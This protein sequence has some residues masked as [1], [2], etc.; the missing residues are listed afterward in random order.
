[1]SDCA[2]GESHI[3]S[4]D[5]LV[6]HGRESCRLRTR[7]ERAKYDAE[8]SAIVLKEADER[9]LVAMGEAIQGEPKAEPHRCACGHPWRDGSHSITNCVTT[10]ATVPLRREQDAPLYAKPADPR[11]K[12]CG[13]LHSEH[14][15]LAHPFGV[16]V[17]R[18]GTFEGYEL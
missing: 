18:K 7:E 11:C 17:C 10:Q 6:I 4:L 9:D 15:T 8:R 1:M 13:Q 16:L 14:L 12:N 5:R 3:K 2:C